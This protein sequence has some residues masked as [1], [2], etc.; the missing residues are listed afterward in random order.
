MASDV[1]DDDLW[2][3]F[4]VVVNMSSRE[5]QDFLAAADA[6]EGSESYPDQAGDDVSRQIVEILGKRRTDLTP[7][8][9]DTMR[10][11]VE[12]IRS[13]TVERHDED[14]SWR[15]WLMSRGHDPLKAP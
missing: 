12:E 7:D 8:D 14:A 10:R 6:G 15:H 3:E 13:G 9:V 2:D 1:I 4:H 5:L 11:V